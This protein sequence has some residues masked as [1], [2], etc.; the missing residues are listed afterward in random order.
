MENREAC[1][2]EGRVA[3]L[4]RRSLSSIPAPPAIRDVRSLLSMAPL[5]DDVA[6]RSGAGLMISTDADEPV[7][8]SELSRRLLAA[9]DVE[10]F[11]DHITVEF[12]GTNALL[13]VVSPHDE[14]RLPWLIQMAALGE[15]T[16]GL[17]H[18]IRNLMTIFEGN[19]QL[20]QDLVHAG[21]ALH[22]STLTVGVM[23]ELAM[24]VTLIGELCQRIGGLSS[25]KKEVKPE[26]LNALV[27]RAVRLCNGPLMNGQQESKFITIDN[28]VDKSF[29]VNVIASQLETAIINLIINAV[30]HGYDHGAVGFITISACHKDGRVHLSIANDGKPMDDAVRAVLMEGAVPSSDGWGVGLYSINRCLREFGSEI[31][32]TSVPGK[33]EFVIN[34]VEGRAA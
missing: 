28:M 1:Q 25:T 5:L 29:F 33:T 9:P 8:I 14:S 10:L 12:E 32:F 23:E 16:A 30:K 15:V 2:K 24:A 4:T 6:T 13:S 26:K 11:L 19:F 3:R 34:M 17:A 20:L 21:I 22:D 18:D 7:Y 31:T 27:A